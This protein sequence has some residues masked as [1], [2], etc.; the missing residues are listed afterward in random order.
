M[1]DPIVSNYGT[2]EEGTTPSNK[3][4]QQPTS[5]SSSSA[6]SSSL[7]SSSSSQPPGPTLEYIS[8]RSMEQKPLLPLSSITTNNHHQSIE[9]RNHGEA[10]DDS[11][12]WPGTA[13]TWIIASSAVVLIAM[14]TTLSVVMAQPPATPKTDVLSGLTAVVTNDYSYR[15][16]VMFPYPF[17]KGAL[18]MEPYRE[19]K[20]TLSGMQDLKSCSLTW[21]LTNYKDTSLVW[22]GT[23]ADDPIVSTTTTT[24]TTN[25]NNNAWE[26]SSTLSS[27]LKDKNVFTVTPTKPGKY[28]LVVVEKCEMVV[29]NT[30]TMDANEIFVP[31][32]GKPNA[33]TS[34]A[35]TTSSSSSTTTDTT[36][37]S[38]VLEQNVWVKYV[39]RE[40]Q[41]LTEGDRNEFLDAFH[42]LWSVNTRDGVEKYGDRYRS[43][44]EIYQHHFQYPFYLPSHTHTL[45]NILSSHTF[46]SP[47]F[48]LPYHL[49]TAHFSMVHNDGGGNGICD[50]FHAGIGFINNHLYLGMYLEQ[51]LRLVNPRVSLHYMEYSKYFESSD[52]E[53]HK[54]NQ[55]DGGSW[56]ELMSSKYFGANDPY[57][58]IIV[59]GRWAKTR[60]PYLNGDF[61]QDEMIDPVNT[62]FPAEQEAWLAIN[63]PHLQN[64]YGLLRSPWNYNPSPYLTRFN[65]V[66]QINLESVSNQAKLSYL[67][68]TCS[69]YNDFIE[70]YALGKPYSAYLF[71]SE[72]SVHG[73]VH[74]AIGGSG[75]NNS[76]AIDAQLM[77]KFNLTQDHI[78][79]V[80]RAAQKFFKTYVPLKNVVS[81]GAND[82]TMIGST[83][84]DQPLDDVH[85]YPIQC[86]PDP[87]QEGRLTTFAGTNRNLYP[88]YSNTTTHR[89]PL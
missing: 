79:Y 69:Q 66:N 70:D 32:T 89:N 65:N 1:A 34:L 20:V 26:L 51:S 50:E 73:N 52:F 24:T 36:S 56:T 59:D 81:V 11:A 27:P 35:T 7:S 67:G 84:I 12:W 48:S 13:P 30:A 86:T 15:N 71:N 54:M 31:M 33:V 68:A 16:L 72:D 78:V 61:F 82:A 43:I 17:L 77:M 60:I 39:R 28:H 37:T 80:A 40:L 46:S 23:T 10:D 62:F 76:A 25:N 29:A 49:S 83:T 14:V 41:S 85:P 74:F 55:L 6:S 75:G 53:K 38:R 18:L 44:G 64:P 19:S 45:L 88:P 2:L 8:F 3:N 57:S 47:P 9:S 5:S 22:T 87:W 63:P 4:E 42:T 21:S 58:G